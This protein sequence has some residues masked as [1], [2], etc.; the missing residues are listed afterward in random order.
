MEGESLFDPKDDEAQDEDFLAVRIDNVSI[1][2]LGF[3]VFLRHG[4]ESRVL[5]IFVGGNEAHSI[6]LVLNGQPTPRPMTH[7]LMRTVLE[8]LGWRVANIRVTRLVENTFYGRI[9]LEHDTHPPMDFDARPSDAIALALRFK[10]HMEVHK[11]VFEQASVPIAKELASG[12]AKVQSEI[13]PES[14]EKSGRGDSIE[15]PSSAKD[16]VHELQ[17]RLAHAIHEEHYEE[18]AKLRDA[19]RAALKKLQTGN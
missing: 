3:I 14:T 12:E 8:N 15:K 2:N 9:Y 13:M 18:A 7:D 6:A 16:P 19:L 17:K 11:S 4:Q 10:A 5:P 1:S